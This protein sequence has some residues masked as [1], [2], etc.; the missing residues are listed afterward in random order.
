MRRGRCGCVCVSRRRATRLVPTEGFS[1][2][3]IRLAT[4]GF[5]FLELDGEIG[6]SAARQHFRGEMIRLRTLYRDFRYAH[7]WEE[8]RDA[9]EAYVHQIRDFHP[10]G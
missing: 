1:V 10:P 7:H 9:Y 4:L 3:A 6:N 2:D 5:T 8:Y